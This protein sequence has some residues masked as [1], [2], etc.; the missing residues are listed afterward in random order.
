MTTLPAF[1]KCV[2]TDI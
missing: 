1:Y 2:T